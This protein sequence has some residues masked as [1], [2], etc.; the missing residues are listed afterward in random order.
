MLG[1]VQ[2][3][4][5]EA[6]VT[7]EQPCAPSAN[8]TS[9]P[10]TGWLVNASVT[11]ADAVHDRPLAISVEPVYTTTAVLAETANGALAE[12]GRK[13]ESPPKVASAG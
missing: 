1:T 6:S 9:T 2:L 8:A 13:L 10:A 5:P 12:A 11:F 4:P 3:A 7:P